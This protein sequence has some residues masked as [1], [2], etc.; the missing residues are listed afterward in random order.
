MNIDHRLTVC[1]IAI[2]GIFSLTSD[3]ASSEESDIAPIKFHLERKKRDGTAI[4][5]LPAGPVG[6]IA[7]VDGTPVFGLEY[8]SHRY[9]IGRA[10]QEPGPLAR[11]LV[12]QA[13]LIAAREHLGCR[14]RD[15]LLGEALPKNPLKNLGRVGIVSVTDWPLGKKKY[16]VFGLAV[17]QEKQ[18]ERQ[19]LL[20]K[21][22]KIEGK[23][24]D[25]LSQIGEK[26]ADASRNEFPA[27]LKKMGVP[28]R[29]I[30][31]PQFAKIPESLTKDAYHLNYLTQYQ[32]IR[33]L[34]QFLDEKG[35][36]WQAYLQLAQAYGH[37]GVLTEYYWSDFS[38]VCKARGML[39]ALRA[40]GLS[41]E[42]PSEYEAFA[43]T[44]LGTNAPGQ[45]ISQA[46]VL[47][48]YLQAI[49]GRHADAAQTL[50]EYEKAVSAGHWKPAK[51][52]QVP[53]YYAKAI[54]AYD[55]DALRKPAETDAPH[56]GPFYLAA[57]YEATGLSSQT[58][59]NYFIAEKQNPECLR[60]SDALIMGRTVGHMRIASET[61]RQKTGSQLVKKA[62]ELSKVSPDLKST[63]YEYEQKASPLVELRSRNELITQ[64]RQLGADKEIKREFNSAVLG[65]MLL[66]RSFTNATASID[67]L[68]HYLGLDAS[69]LIRYYEFICRTHPFRDYIQ[70]QQ[71]N[72]KLA[73]AMLAQANQTMPSRPAPAFRHKQLMMPM[74][75][76]GLQ[77][78][79]LPV[80]SSMSRMNQVDHTYSSLLALRQF[81]DQYFV[82]S[83]LEG[84]EKI[85]PKSEA[86]PL[87]VIEAKSTT[88]EELQEVE[89]QNSDSVFVLASLVKRYDFKDR[90][91]KK[92]K[93]PKT[94]QENIK[95]VLEQL[96]KISDDDFYLSQLA[97]LYQNQEQEKEW[98]ALS[99]KMLELPIQ[100]LN[101]VHWE[102]QLAYWYARQNDQENALKHA[103]HAFR[104]R[105]GNSYNCLVNIQTKYGKYDDANKVLALMTDH[106]KSAALQWLS[107]CIAHNTGDEQTA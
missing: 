34:H 86:A 72:S 81:A 18:N 53:L 79:Q 32:M 57:I 19:F 71:T 27:L 93:A 61:L 26:M 21:N 94:E 51:G 11:E 55:L 29:P 70:L 16:L 84:M 59:K 82:P 42:K 64:L 8:L 66:E 97:Y 69:D 46:T 74:V 96:V 28:Q 23:E 41:S 6:T 98:V 47:L 48:A 75:N 14:T 1:L 7:T 25:I 102:I 67:T 13:L 3:H 65:Q 104:S 37:L 33:G 95:R 99:K 91:E 101:T 17:Y 87:S 85:S 44:H 77:M 40:K 105:S 92:D 62:G 106:Y 90:Y 73:I 88:P 56:L 31:K 52:M 10:Q 2:T 89:K 5:R 49:Y 22:Y 83:L 38:S 15:V 4:S 50:A 24:Y 12:R 80:M 107:W 30:S 9:F 100:S 20:E 36:N 43:K 54:S 63:I 45:S 35:P 39:Y 103:E 76:I 78:A 60:L 58:L 68:R